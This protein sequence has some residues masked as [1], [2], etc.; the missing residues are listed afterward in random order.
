MLDHLRP[1]TPY[2]PTAPAYKEWLHLN[3]FDHASG[4]I[5]IVNATLQGTPDSPSA[6]AVGTALVDSPGIG[7]RGG[8][9]VQEATQAGVGLCSIAMDV[10]AIAADTRTGAVSSSVDLPEAGLRCVV[11]ADPLGKGLVAMAPSDFG[12]GWISWQALPRLRARGQLGA[13]VLT[14]ATAYLDHNWGRWHWGEAWTAWQWGVFHGVTSTVVLSRLSDRTHRRSGATMLEVRTGDRQR[15]FVG[16]MVDINWQL[17][18]AA[19]LFRVPG[20]LAAL[21]PDRARPRLPRSMVVTAGDGHDRIE[22]EFTSRSAAQ[23]VLADPAVRGYS[24]LYEFTGTFAC[25]GRLSGVPYNDSG[26]AVTERVE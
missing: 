19:P 8:L 24:F 16:K 14:D 25:T 4:T 9:A 15:R 21:H 13:C 12:S 1:P 18:M 7:W 11:E 3:V 2:D 17:P 6:C 23:L 5:G 10:L 26:L 20:A 22:L